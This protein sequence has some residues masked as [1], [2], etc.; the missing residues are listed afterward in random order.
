MKP[1]RT[2]VLVADDATARFLI[3]E[4]IGKGLKEIAGL[5]ARQFA[6][7]QIAYDDRPGRQTGGADG[8]ARHGF[9]PH[10]NADEMGRARFVGYVA[11][12]LSRE[13]KRHSPDRLIVA[14]PPKTLGAL[15][16]K[17]NGAPA[18]ALHGD[19]AKDLVRVSVQDLPKHFA[20]ILPM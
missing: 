20:D 18:A 3:N 8:T 2:L 15:R 5:S 4:G 17:L 19:L 12:E 13:W 14:A 10:E 1:I 16:A 7:A 9:D 6:D 11:E